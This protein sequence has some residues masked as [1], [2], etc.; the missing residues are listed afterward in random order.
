MKLE[1]KRDGSV[2]STTNYTLDKKDGDFVRG[3]FLRLVTDTDDDAESGDQTILVKLGDKI[4][5]SY[6]IAAGSTVEQEIQVGRP[7]SEDNNE[8]AKPWKH[9]I[10]EVNVRIVAVKDEAGNACVTDVQVNELVDNANERLAQSGIRLKRTQDTVEVIDPPSKPADDFGPAYTYD[11]QYQ[12]T[13]TLEPP[14]EDEVAF[15]RSKDNNSNTIDIFFIKQFKDTVDGAAMAYYPVRNM[16]GQPVFNNF[17]VISATAVRP[18][19][20]PHEIMHVL[21]NRGHRNLEPATALFY[22]PS[23]LNKAV[24]GKK[25]IGPYPQSTA[26]NVGDDDTT[27]MRTNAENLP[28]ERG[29][30]RQDKHR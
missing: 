5:V 11:Q 7:S 24:Y 9:D 16:S 25:R 13:E 19:T 26:A 20:M 12:D 21:L 17:I 27:T 3:Q 28:R 6:D 15:S 4:K 30:L 8:A 14:S 22:S 29:Q 10:R 18:F 23:A 2:V 1:V